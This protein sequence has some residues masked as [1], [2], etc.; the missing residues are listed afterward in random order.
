[1]GKTGFTH[2]FDFVP[3]SVAHPERIIKAINHPNKDAAT[4]LL[5]SWTDTKQTR[6]A[7]SAM[8]AILN[9]TE[10]PLNADVLAALE[11]C[12]VQTVPWTKRQE[13]ATKL[14]A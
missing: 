2:H 7:R 10:R 5:F 1:M 11:H 8:Y 4:S 12:D 6:P 3:K 13:H 9:D 14:A